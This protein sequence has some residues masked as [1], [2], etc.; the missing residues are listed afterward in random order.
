MDLTKTIGELGREKEKL[1]RVI[2]PLE[3]LRASG[4]VPAKKRRGR[5]SI[6]LEERR[7]IS[8]KIKRYWADRHKQREPW[9]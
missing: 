9:S 5:K 4:E 2:A 1:E 3:E 7:Q 8:A 6:S